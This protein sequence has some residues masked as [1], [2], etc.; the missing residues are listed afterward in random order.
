MKKIVL[1]IVICVCFCTV[2]AAQVSSGTAMFVNTRA[3]QLKS[4]SGFFS[5]VVANLAYGDQVTVVSDA[6]A[7]A[8]WVEVRSAANSSHKGWVEYSSLTTKRIV[9]TGG[10]ASASEIALAGKGFDAKF[11]STANPGGSLNFTDVDL[12]E[13]IVV[14]SDKLKKFITDGKLVSP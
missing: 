9:S 7:N 1:A 4:S 6:A 5:S 13:A 11:V 3:A 14:N 8:K 12:V 10:G 2:A